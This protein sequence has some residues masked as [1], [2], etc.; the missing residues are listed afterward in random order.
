MSTSP[1]S[2]EQLSSGRTVSTSSLGLRAACEPKNDLKQFER[3]EGEL[4]QSFA[5]TRGLLDFSAI[6][7]N[8]AES[9]ES[10]PNKRSKT[11]KTAIKVTNKFTAQSNRQKAQLKQAKILLAKLRRC[12]VKVDPLLQEF[13]AEAKFQQQQAASLRK[14]LK[15]AQSRK[16]LAS[17]AVN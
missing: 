2:A 10:V 16:D 9:L 7:L 11:V 13:V 6:Q 14:Q 12:G 3:L 5:T 15:A 17:Q 1:S 8:D 4:S